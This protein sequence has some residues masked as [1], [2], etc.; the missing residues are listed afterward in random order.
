MA[1]QVMDQSAERKRI[2]EEKKRLKEEQKRAKKEAKSRAKELARQESEIEDD[3]EGSSV[4][5]VLVT[6]VIILIW[7]AILVLLVKTDVGGFGSGVLA[8]ILKDVPVVN[9]ILP[10]SA[11]TETED[12]SEYMG[13]KSLKEAVDQIKKL[14]LQLEQANSGN[15]ASA[16]EV[17]A[18]RAEIERLKTFENNQVEFQR[19][20]TEFYE[21]V[22]YSEKGPGAEEYRKYYEEMDPTTAEYLYKE[23]VKEEEADAKVRDYAQAYSEMKPKEAAAIFEAM[24]DDLALAAKILNMMEPDA[25]GKILGVM[26]AEVAAKLTK[27]M[28]PTS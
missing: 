26:D 22:V 25:R 1:E 11:A 14:E 9:K 21:E 28:N 10:G 6:A 5:V 8:P 18:L 13:Y 15:T 16:E 7:L 24:T 4:S 17:A 3:T 20:K 23:V 27:I 2:K 12:E 19:I